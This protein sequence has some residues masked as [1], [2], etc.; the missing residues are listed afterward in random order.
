MKLLAQK[1]HYDISKLQ[2][3]K[4]QTELRIDSKNITFINEKI[5][6]I[7]TMYQD[8]LKEIAS[9]SFL[10]FSKALQDHSSN[11]FNLGK[12]IVDTLENISEFTNTKHTVL[13]LITSMEKEY[14]GQIKT[15]EGSGIQE[16]NDIVHQ[17]WG[18]IN[19]PIFEINHTP[20]SI[21]KILMAF[22]IV[23][24]GFIL[25]G[26]YKNKIQ[27]LKLSKRS[28][29]ASTRIILANVGYYIILLIALFMVLNVLGI[30]LSSLALVAGAL[31][32]GM[33]FGLKN[34]VSNFVSGLIMMFEHSVKIGDY[35]QL[36][37]GLCG[38]VTD[39][40]MRSTTIN[41]ND[42]I[43]VI[44]PNQNFIETNVINWT[45][46]DNIRRFSIPFGV[47]YGTNPQTVIDVIVN[48]VKDEDKFTNVIHESIERETHVI[49]TKMGDSSVD[50]ELL[51]WITGVKMRRPKRTTSEFLILIYNT[52]YE[53]NIEIP[54]PQ[55]DLHVRSTEN[56]LPTE[57]ANV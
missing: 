35:I 34:I 23:G 43:D 12:H 33:G 39:I 5:V 4:E 14:L 29:P 37:D 44:V 42:N 24:I 2:I 36:Q 54:F 50:F 52:L 20:V 19:H 31:S 47:K 27:N 49:M 15:L 38:Y 57:E 46:K 55:I 48:A 16:L 32:V 40:R 22:L 13:I 7:Q 11:V 18:F 8:T 10:L 1:L 21:F 51:V 3:G 26:V 25:G 9:Y 41:T 53:N 56:H 17:G 6:K 28:F 30:R 45:M